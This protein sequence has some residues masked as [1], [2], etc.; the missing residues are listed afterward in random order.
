MK[1][2]G[3]NCAY[4]RGDCREGRLTVLSCCLGYF[5]PALFLER[6]SVRINEKL[7]DIWEMICNGRIKVDLIY[8]LDEI[9]Y[10]KNEPSDRAIVIIDLHVS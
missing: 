6:S 8:T 4:R 9:S 7:L 1:S 10:E 2:V 3:S 5:L